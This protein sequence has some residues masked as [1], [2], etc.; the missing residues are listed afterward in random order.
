M[1]RDGLIGCADPDCWAYCSP[2]CPP[3]Q[4]CDA[5]DRR[6]GDG[7]CSAALETCQACPQDCGACPS[8]CGDYACTAGES[9]A[10]CAGDCP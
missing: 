2:F 4:P 6:C 3:G 8:V 9:A 5:A 7:T 10:S 1:D